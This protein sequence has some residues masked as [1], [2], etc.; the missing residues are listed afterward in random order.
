M[1]DG[2]SHHFIGRSPGLWINAPFYQP[3]AIGDIAA[4]QNN[5]CAEPPF[6]DMLIVGELTGKRNT[7]G[8][9]VG[10]GCGIGAK[11]E[12]RRILRNEDHAVSLMRN[13]FL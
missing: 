12:K 5:G 3:A 13:C 11:K 9:C 8:V 4:A 6:R 10:N 1:N 7:D 2:F